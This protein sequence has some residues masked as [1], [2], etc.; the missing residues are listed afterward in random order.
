MNKTFVMVALNAG[1]LI[2]IDMVNTWGGN[3]TTVSHAALAGWL[4]IIG[5]MGLVTIGT[6]MDEV[7]RSDEKK[8]AP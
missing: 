5:I 3:W 6:R 2:G 8:E 7:L 1:F 4:I